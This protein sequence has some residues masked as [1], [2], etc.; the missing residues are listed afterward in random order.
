MIVAIIQNDKSAQFFNDRCLRKRQSF[1]VKYG[2]AFYTVNIIF[3][4]I[5]ISRWATQKL[6]HGFFIFAAEQVFT[7]IAKA[8]IYIHR[9]TNSAWNPEN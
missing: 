5:N 7:R 4:V 3:R 6:S 2:F 8:G 9:L 1:F